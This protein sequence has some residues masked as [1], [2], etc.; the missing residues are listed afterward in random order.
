MPTPTPQARYRTRIFAR[1]LGPFVAVATLIIAIRLPQLGDLLSD[2]FTSGTLPWMLGA[3]MLLM[4][5]VVIAF[6]QYW[7]SVTAVLISLFGWFVALRGVAMM[8]FPSAIESGADA[9]VTSP[10][11][12]IAA[13]AFF[14]VLA[15]MGLWFSYVGWRPE[16]PA[17]S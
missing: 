5:L 17:G 11:P 10:G 16:A 2:L 3:A 15:A 8:A 6:H 4:G 7:Y 13:R 12:L 1:V 14:L 9:A